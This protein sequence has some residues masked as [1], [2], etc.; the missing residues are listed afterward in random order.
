V[1]GRFVQQLQKLVRGKRRREKKEKGET[2]EGK[3]FVFFLLHERKAKE[4]RERPQ[5]TFL[6][7]KGR[8]KPFAK[9][10]IILNRQ[11]KGRPLNRKKKQKCSNY[12]WEVKG[13]NHRLVKRKREFFPFTY[14]EK[15]EKGGS[16][17]LLSKGRRQKG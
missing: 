9:D 12:S 15:E 1:R 5:T 14:N 8:R 2:Q 17:L 7:G 3:E 4:R 16:N 13:K 11:K 10:T 6:R